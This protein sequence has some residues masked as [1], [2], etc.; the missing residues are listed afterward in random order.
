MD[1]E[2]AA[3]PDKTRQKALNP[4]AKALYVAICQYKRANDG[5]APSLRELSETCQISS[6]SV[7][8]YHLR[9]LERAGLIEMGSGARSIRVTGGRWELDA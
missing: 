7:I 3:V 6:T 5:I 1:M 9:R 8:K 4:R 2:V